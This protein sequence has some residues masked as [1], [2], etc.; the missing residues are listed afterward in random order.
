MLRRNNVQPTNVSL[1]LF[2]LVTTELF[3]TAISKK[4]VVFVGPH[5]THTNTNS[6]LSEYA[7]D[8]G[9]GSSSF[10]G[11][12]WPSEFIDRNEDISS[13]PQHVFDILAKENNND[14]VQDVL[15][16]AI[17]SAWSDSENGIFVGSLDFD[18]VGANPYSRYDAVGALQR[19]V[20]EVRIPAE[21][22]TVIVTYSVPRVGQWGKVWRNHF[23]A[24]TYEEFVCSSDRQVDK[25]WEWLDTSMNPFK[26]AKAYHDQ[27]WNVATH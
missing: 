21:D 16:D 9:S 25:R 3:G 15:I 26:I 24:E 12:S 10:D 6:F 23:Y 17:R 1:F 20:N 2:L 8:D 22:V 5:E 19:V 18:K 4:F 27:G 14:D 7:A 13:T 11:W